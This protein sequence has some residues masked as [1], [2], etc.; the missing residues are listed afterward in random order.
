M[1]RVSVNYPKGDDSTFDHDYYTGSHVPL[2]IEVWNP[3]KVEVDKIVNGPSVAAVQIYFDSMEQFNA[4]MSH[5]RTAEIMNDVANY[6]NITPSM[7]VAEV[8]AI[9]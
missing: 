1:I 8:V 3:K 9:A 6:T 4:A 5:P 2:C 7:Q